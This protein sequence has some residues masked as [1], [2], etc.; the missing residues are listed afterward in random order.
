MPQEPSGLA[1]E[2]RGGATFMR[3]PDR[4]RCTRPQGRKAMPRRGSRRLCGWTGFAFRETHEDKAR[5]SLL[6]FYR[7]AA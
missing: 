7:D 1:Q 4:R 2:A 3:L 5:Q 6:C